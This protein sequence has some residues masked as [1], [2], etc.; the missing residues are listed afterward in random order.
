MLDKGLGDPKATSATASTLEVVRTAKWL[1]VCFRTQP[2]APAAIQADRTGLSYI[3]PPYGF[4]EVRVALL[5]LLT[6]TTL[7][8]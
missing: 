7:P 5:T 3:N 6:L 1:T 8:A 4:G 2:P